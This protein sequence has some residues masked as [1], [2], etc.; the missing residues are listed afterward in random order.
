MAFFFF[1]VTMA[2]SAYIKITMTAGVIYSSSG[3][4]EAESDLQLGTSEIRKSVKK[5]RSDMKEEKKI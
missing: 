4:I 3:A 1:I 5:I 2:S